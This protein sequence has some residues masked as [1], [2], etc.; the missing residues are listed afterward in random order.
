MDEECREPCCSLESVQSTSVTFSF[1]F[2]LLTR[3]PHDPD[4]QCEGKLRCVQFVRLCVHVC[5]CACMHA[6]TLLCIYLCIFVTHLAIYLTNKYVRRSII[7]ILH[8]HVHS[9]YIRLRITSSHVK[10]LKIQQRRNDQCKH[11][12][13]SELLN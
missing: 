3:G 9:Q 6:C 5:L 13:Y 12:I 8:A 7:I 4:G 11:K 1:C 10:K 2:L